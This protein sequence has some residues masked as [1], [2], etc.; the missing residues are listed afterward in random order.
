MLKL[1]LISNLIY[2]NMS[3]NKNEFETIDFADENFTDKKEILK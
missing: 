3:E 1:L 2:K